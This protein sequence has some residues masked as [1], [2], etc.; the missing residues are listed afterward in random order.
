[1]MDRYEYLSA[2]AKMRHGCIY[3][4]NR[5]IGFFRAEQLKRMDGVEHGFT[6]RQG[7]VS[8][9]PYDSLHLNFQKPHDLALVRE[10]FSR[11]ADAAG[12]ADAASPPSHAIFARRRLPTASSG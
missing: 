6:A 9:K 3:E 1:M 12:I 4:E 5:G 10:N 2:Y 7:G 11:F 8:P